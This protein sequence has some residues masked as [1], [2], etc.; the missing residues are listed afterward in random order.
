MAGFKSKSQQ[1]QYGQLL[2]EG[3]ITQAQYDKAV[4]DTEPNLPPRTTWP[5]GLKPM[6]I[7][8]LRA[9]KVAK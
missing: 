3:K 7:K 2:G 8:I 1:A 9:Q 6:K 4:A 5:K